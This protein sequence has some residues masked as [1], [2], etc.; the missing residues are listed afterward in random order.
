MKKIFLFL[1][2]ISLFVTVLPNQAEAAQFKD[3]PRDH[4]AHDEIRFLTN[5]QVIKG[6]AGG[7]FQ[8]LKVLRRKD[9]AIIV[10][11]ALKWPKPA[12]PTVKPSDVKVTMGGYN[13]IMAAVNKGLFTMDGNKFNPDKPLS[14]KEMAR[15]IS[16]AYGYA[17]KGS[18]TFKDVPKSNGYYKYIDAIASNGIT[19]G[20]KDGTFKP[21]ET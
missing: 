1:L 18:S 3:V 12:T 21:D 14:R 20:Y 16:V 4:W 19:S 8:P 17:G 7:T 9:A 13:E 2:S 5:K 11:R 10:V 15:V 6:Y